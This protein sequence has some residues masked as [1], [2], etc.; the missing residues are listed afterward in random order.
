[1]KP[2]LS[3]SV[4]AEQQVVAILASAV[5]KLMDALGISDD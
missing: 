3:P 2:P 5:R 4:L 1:M